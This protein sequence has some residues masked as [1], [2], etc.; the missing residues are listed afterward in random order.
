VCQRQFETPHLGQ[1]KSP[2]PFLKE[3]EGATGNGR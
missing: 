3:V 1:L 2:H